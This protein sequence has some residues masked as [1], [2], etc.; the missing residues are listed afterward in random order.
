MAN[1]AAFSSAK[2]AMPLLIAAAQTRSGFSPAKRWR[3]PSPSRPTMASA[4]TR[5]SSKNSV[6]CVSG[7][8]NAVSIGVRVRPSASA[9]TMN[10][11]S[12]PR[13]RSSASPLRATTMM[14]ST[15]STAEV[16]YLVPE[17]DQPFPACVAWVEILCVFVP[18]SGSVIAKAR[19]LVPSARPGSQSRLTSSEPCASRI[20]EQIELMTRASTGQPCAATSSTI[21]L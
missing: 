19:R 20:G 7:T 12:R 2:R 5:T 18:A 8:C 9:G 1:F 21:T 10:S 11:E 16:Q 15:S 3:M 6:N 13:P 14:E 17:I 4:G